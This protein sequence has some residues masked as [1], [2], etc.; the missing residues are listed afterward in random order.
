MPTIDTQAVARLL[1]EGKTLRQIATELEGPGD[2]PTADELRQQAAR[3]ALRND[4]SPPG[5]EPGR[6]VWD[7]AYDTF[8]SEMKAGRR[9]KDAGAIA[10]DGIL[11]VAADPN[12]PQRDK[13][14]YDPQRWAADH[15]LRQVSG[16]AR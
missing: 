16:F 11:A 2:G 12:H 9:R 3:Q 6:D 5:A 15:G 10:L 4:S 7:Q 1:A 8:H 13:V 14:V